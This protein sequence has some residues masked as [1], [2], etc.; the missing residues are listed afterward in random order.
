M[1]LKKNKQIALIAFTILF[2]LGMVSAAWAAQTIN[3][4]TLTQPTA[5]PNIAE[6]Q[7]FTMGGQI[8]T[9]GGGGWSESGDRFMDNHHGDRCAF[10]V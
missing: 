8:S 2:L 3:G 9:Q 1:S 4:V 7:T 5:D 6:T 10:Y